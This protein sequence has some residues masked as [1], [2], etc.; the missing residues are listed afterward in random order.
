MHA[1]VRCVFSASRNGAR[2]CRDTLPILVL[3]VG[4]VSIANSL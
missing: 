1:G 3:V 2:Q 4:L